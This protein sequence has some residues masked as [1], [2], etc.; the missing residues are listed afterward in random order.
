LPI[1]GQSL[2]FHFAGHF[3]TL[4]ENVHLS[5]WLKPDGDIAG[6]KCIPHVPT[7]QKHENIKI[8]SARRERERASDGVRVLKG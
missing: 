5:G 1:I 3:S 6:A 7:Y 2:V 8:I 4:D